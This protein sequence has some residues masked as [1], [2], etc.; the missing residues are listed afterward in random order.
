MESYCYMNKSST[1]SFQKG[2]SSPSLEAATPRET[3]T[4][5]RVCE[6]NRVI[7][8]GWLLFLSVI[9]FSTGFVLYYPTLYQTSDQ[10]VQSVSM[11]TQNLL[12]Y[13]VVARGDFGPY[14]EYS[15]I[16]S[17]RSLNLMSMPFQQV[18]RNLS[19]LLKTTYNADKV[20]IIP[21][22]V[23]LGTLFE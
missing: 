14:K 1:T 20:A 23:I 21:G 16:H 5:S 4:T 6:N 18:M 13:P 10:L 17:D 3:R 11:A 2:R 12:M 15:V 19:Q 9:L 8:N 7:A 22:C